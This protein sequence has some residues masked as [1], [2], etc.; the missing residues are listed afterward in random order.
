MMAHLL[1]S[2]EN[3]P[4][5]LSVLGRLMDAHRIH[6][7]QSCI[8][9]GKDFLASPPDDGVTLACLGLEPVPIQDLDIAAAVA[10]QACS[11]EVAS[12]QRQRGSAHPEHL[13]VQ[14]SELGAFED[15]AE[16]LAPVVSHGIAL[17]RQHRKH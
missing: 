2:D 5:A 3:Q 9:L 15:A 13:E 4:A 1:F 6:T 8:C 10:D 12:N 16:A 14:I 17:A 11:L 7:V